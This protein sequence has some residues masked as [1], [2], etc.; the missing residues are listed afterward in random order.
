M[1]RELERARENKSDIE[2]GGEGGRNMEKEERQIER[3]R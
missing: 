1:R 3:D 2:R